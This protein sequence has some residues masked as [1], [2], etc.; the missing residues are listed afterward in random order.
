M[1]ESDQIINCSVR[2]TSRDTSRV[3]FE[4]ANPID[5]QATL[6]VWRIRRDRKTFVPTPE[7]LILKSEIRRRTVVVATV[8]IGDLVVLRAKN[9]F[10][11]AT[12][13]SCYRIGAGFSPSLED[14]ASSLRKTG[15]IA[16]LIDL[17]TFDDDPPI[18]FPA[19][20]LQ[21][22]FAARNSRW[23][24]GLIDEQL[25]TWKERVPELFIRFAPKALIDR[26]LPLLVSHAPQLALAFY[27]EQL[28]TDQLESC[29][30]ANPDAALRHAYEEMPQ[31][32]KFQSLARHPSFG[33]QHL[34]YRL[35]DAELRLCA[36]LAPS[37]A[38]QMRASLSANKHAI[39]LA[40]SFPEAAL[41]SNIGGSSTSLKR[42][43]VVSLLRYPEEW[44]LASNQSIPYLFQ[45]LSTWL[46]LYL[47]PAELQ[48]LARRLSPAHRNELF[49]Y[50]AEGI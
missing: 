43:I 12:Q 34:L 7:G 8:G 46:D 17:I 6:E 49:Q 40:A 31:K 23:V 21:R 10:E 25:S 11:N 2:R 18:R 32:L 14:T 28:T 20:E 33:L 16:S 24:Q 35:S 4:I 41:E 42:E 26:E 1:L 38:F 45:N 27:K 36:K 44:L 48:R 15:V 37:T 13:F 50:I 3:A 29:I 47:K 19:R 9:P 5:K 30:R 22:F 39:I